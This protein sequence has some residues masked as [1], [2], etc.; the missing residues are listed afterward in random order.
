MLCVAKVPEAAVRQRMAADGVSPVDIDAFFTGGLSRQD[1]IRDDALD[2]ADTATRTA[3]DKKRL[4]A[5]AA[6]IKRGLPE[7]AVR[8][9]M[10]MDKVPVAAVEDFFQRFL[11]ERLL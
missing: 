10:A 1:G 9:K 8:Q 6:M 5:Y 3:P 2:A 11:P 4:E 7:A